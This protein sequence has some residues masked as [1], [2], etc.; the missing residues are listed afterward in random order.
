MCNEYETFYM[1]YNRFRQ[2]SQVGVE[3]EGFNQRNG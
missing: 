3:S 2:I 1:L